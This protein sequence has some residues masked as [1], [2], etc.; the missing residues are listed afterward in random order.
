MVQHR[1]VTASCCHPPREEQE[2]QHHHRDSSSPARPDTLN[3]RL[4]DTPRWQHDGDEKRKNQTVPLRD[5]PLLLVLRS[6]E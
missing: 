3:E 2:D 5:R 6:N 1:R 4:I